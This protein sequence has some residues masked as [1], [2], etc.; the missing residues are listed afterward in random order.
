M[1]PTNK[2]KKN[3]ANP[4]SSDCVIYQGPNLECI[5]LCKGDTITQVEY[6]LATKLCNLLEQFN[7]E[8]YDISC[9]DLQ[10]PEPGTFQDLIKTLI[11]AICEARTTPGPA[12]PAGP[13]GEPGPIGPSGSPGSRGDA[14]VGIQGPPGIQGAKG[15]KG[16]KGDQGDPGNTGPKGDT[17]DTGPEG[18]IGPQ[19]DPGE[20]AIQPVV[21]FTDTCDIEFTENNPFPNYDF[22]AGI[23]DSGWINLDGFNHITTDS[24]RPKAR[25]YG[26]KVY[27]TGQAFI[28][29][30]NLSVP[31]TARTMSNSVSYKDIAQ[32]APF[33]GVGGVTINTDGALQYNNNTNVF[34]TLPLP[35]RTYTFPVIIQRRIELVGGSFSTMLT[36]YAWL[37]FSSAGIMTLGTLKDFEEIDTTTANSFTPSALRYITSNVRVGEYAPNYKDSNIHSSGVVSPTVPVAPDTDTNTPIKVNYGD[38]GTYPITCDAGNE[39]E[40]GGF[41]M[42]LDGIEMFINC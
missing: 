3:C 10:T 42:F 20:D 24:V 21:E 18:P 30:E 26:K 25:V 36:G 4:T 5:E 19:G 14:G 32:V 28:P 17:G 13:Q 35:D 29:L 7:I 34:S 31:G 15:D 12:G 2:N 39:S 37:T 22:S 9:L 38:D 33:T 23:K 11:E 8:N 1:E 41:Y 16:D 6:K 40:I 27:L